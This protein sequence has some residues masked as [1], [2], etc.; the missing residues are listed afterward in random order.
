[1]Q[2]Q[3]G[4]ADIKVVLDSVLYHTKN[5][6]VYS[7]KVNWDTLQQKAMALAKDATTVNDLKPALSYVLNSLGDYHGRYLKTADYSPIATFTDWNK[8]NASAQDKRERKREELAIVN[9]PDIKFCYS[10][11]PGNTAYLRVVGIGFNVNLQAEADSIR[12]AI[13]FFANRKVQKWIVDLRY[14]GGGNMNPMMA[15]L[16][17]LLDSGLVG[18]LSGGSAD[19]TDVWTIRNNNFIW[20]D[21]QALQM[22]KYPRLKAGRKIAVLTSRYTVSSGEFVATAFKNNS[23]TKFFGEATGGYT[24]ST[25]W[26]TVGNE[27]IVCIS[28][29]YYADR[30]GTVYNL[31]IPVNEEAVFIPNQAPGADDGIIKALTWLNKK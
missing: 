20:G 13:L 5:S 12:K 24:T 2:A 30:K 1:M 15:G 21:Y 7:N 4:T 23:G 19:A 27:I 31:N 6:S 18:S 29:G 14:N 26:I 16:A 3:P 22:N 11:L 17:P 25:N 28:H 10:L 9:A 8:L